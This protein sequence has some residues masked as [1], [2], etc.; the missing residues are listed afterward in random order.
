MTR[1]RTHNDFPIIEDWSLKLSF[2]MATK[3]KST[4][5]NNRS[6][7][8]ER[9]SKI[10]RVNE[11]TSTPNED[12][13]MINETKGKDDIFDVNSQC[14]FHV[15]RRPV[16]PANVSAESHPLLDVE[17]PFSKRLVELGFHDGVGDHPL[18]LLILKSAK[19]KTISGV[20]IVGSADIPEASI[21]KSHQF[22]QGKALYKMTFATHAWLEYFKTLPGFI[23][24]DFMTTGIFDHYGYAMGVCST[25]SIPKCAEYFQSLHLNEEQI[26]SFFPVGGAA[27][28]R[29]PSSLQEEEQRRQEIVNSI[30]YMKTLHGSQYKKL[31]KLGRPL[32]FRVRLEIEE[33]E[34]SD[35]ELFEKILCFRVLESNCPPV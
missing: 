31:S 3:S 33:M 26:D 9:M 6:N 18:G 30:D 25:M 17:A 7:E 12:E 10:S 2:I 11:V 27:I 8:D 13:A 22:H 14:N 4:R 19:E 32:K 21:C 24:T 35:M 1:H 5:S 23:P 28:A 16:P 15:A 29:Q 20:I 34:I